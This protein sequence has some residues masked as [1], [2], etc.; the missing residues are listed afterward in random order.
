MSQENVDLMRAAYASLE[1]G[2]EAALRK[3]D[4]I[5]APDIEIRSVGRVPDET[6]VRGREAAKAWFARLM[7]SEDFEFR[8][9]PE[10]F[11][12]AG[13]A[14]VVVTRQIARGR[15]SGI[16][17]TNRLV[18]VWGFRNGKVIWFDAYRTR[19]EA[20]EAAGLSE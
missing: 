17:V 13:D 15:A 1:E 10:E 6:P 12:D 19:A 11:I 3:T 9:E 14:V 16:E 5:V 8:V 18:N 20:L 2:V 4:E 7:R